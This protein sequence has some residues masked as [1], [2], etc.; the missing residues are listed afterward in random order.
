MSAPTPEN[1]TYRRS[2]WKDAALMIF[3]VLFACLGLFIP[4]L[5]TL[6]RAFI[7]TVGFVN[8]SFAFYSLINND[9]L[10][11]SRNGVLIKG[12]FGIRSYN[13]EIVRSIKPSGRDSISIKTTRK[14][15]PGVE[16]DHLSKNSKE[17]YYE[18]MAARRAWDNATAASEQSSPP[19]PP[20]PSRA[21]PHFQ[22]SRSPK[23]PSLAQPPKS[24][25]VEREHRQD[26]GTVLVVAGIT[27]GVVGY[28][29]FKPLAP[30]DT[31]SPGDGWI[32]NPVEIGLVIA[33][34]GLILGAMG[35]WDWAR[36]NGKRDKSEATPTYLRYA[37]GFLGVPILLFVATEVIKRVYPM[38]VVS[39]A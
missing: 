4:G 36:F 23:L 20:L 22:P 5:S 3:G 10:T 34:F 37:L 11:I 17:I 33:I 14:S 28:A 12:R 30:G 26:L 31:L 29:I 2:L 9:I 7:S 35:V 39:P 25:T 32:V 8:A 19:P 27:L 18:I 6:Q 1:L 24:W 15:D 21:P 16:L 13:W 38:L